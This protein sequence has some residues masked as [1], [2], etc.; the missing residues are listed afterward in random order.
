VLDFVSVM[1]MVL[2]RLFWSYIWRTPRAN[3]PTTD[4]MTVRRIQRLLIANRGEIAVRIIRACRERGIETVAVYSEADRS[5]LHVRLADFA[6]PIGPPPANRSYLVQE[7]LLEVARHAEVDGVH[8]GYGFLSENASFAQRCLEHGL[9]FVGPPPDAIR[10]M[11]DKVAARA[12]MREADVPMAPGSADA[13][14][15]LDQARDLADRFGYPVLVKAAAGGGGKGMRVVDSADELERAVRAAQGEAESAF[16]DARVFIEKFIS[17]PRHIEVQVLADSFGGAVHLFERECS[18]QRRHQ[19]VIEESPSS[20][21]TPE[22]RAAL[23]SAAL[24]AARACGYVNA[25]T[26]EF[27]VD[28]DRRFYFMEMNTRLQ[29]EHPVTEW[30][31]GIDL[32]GEQIRIAEGEALGYAQQDVALRGHSIECRIY[33]EDVRNGFLPAPGPLLRYRAPGGL[34]VRVDEGVDQGRSVPMYYD[35]MIAKLSTWGPTRQE[36]INRMARALAEYEIAGVETTIPFCSFVMGH[37][38]FRSGAFDTHFVGLHWRPDQLD[39][40]ADLREFAAVLAAAHVQA[41]GGAGGGPLPTHKPSNPPAVE[42]K[43][44]RRRWSG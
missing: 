12:L 10:I 11:G 14:T 30:V 6:Y 18:I 1:A 32:V 2:L 37:E 41:T 19:K 27:L 3:L 39:S 17:S 7:N 25:G 15:D 36:A 42:S 16:G 5:A 8:P 43:W 35:P 44:L 24:Q 31:T 38:A 26:V 4:K 13:L 34:G 20:F 21:V 28:A 9:V 29:V 23:G 22:L 40:D 33:A